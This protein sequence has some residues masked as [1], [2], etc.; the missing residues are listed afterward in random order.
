MGNTY[1]ERTIFSTTLGRSI[2][3]SADG[4]PK[5]KAGGVTIDWDYVPALSADTTFEDGVTVLNGEKALR[6]GSVVYRLGSGKYGLADNTTTLKRG[7]VYIVNETWLEEEMTSN[8]PGVID[9]G[10]IFK[11]RL[12]V[13]TSAVNDVQTLTVTAT[14]GTFKVISNINGVTRA[15]AAVAYDASAATLQTALEGLSNIGSGNVAVSK[16]GSVFTVTFQGTLASTNVPALLVDASAATGG[17]VTQATTSDGAVGKPTLAN[18]EAA[19][20]GIVY[21]ID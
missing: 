16:T 9:G 17:T 11:D 19:M 4:A 10:R 13:G 18:V 14:G 20:P 3:V 5:F 15:T 1:G 7:E 2:Q 12:L 8:H 6:Y 21:A